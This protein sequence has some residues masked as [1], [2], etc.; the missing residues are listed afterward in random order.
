MVIA[1][2]QQIAQPCIGSHRPAWRVKPGASWQPLWQVGSSTRPGQQMPS[3]DMLP[4]ITKLEFSVHLLAIRSLARS[5]VRWCWI[6][7]A[8]GI[9]VVLE[10]PSARDPGDRAEP[11][12]WS[13]HGGRI[14]QA[15]KFASFVQADNVCSHAAAMMFHD[16]KRSASTL[17]TSCRALRIIYARREYLTA[18]VT[19]AL[20]PRIE[21]VPDTGGPAASPQL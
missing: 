14:Q 13:A 21:A 10:L 1:K 2:I 11:R 6:D 7:C 4:P 5:H 17:S 3:R 16:P 19:A 20:K 8:H 9:Y 18:A 12:T 15:Y